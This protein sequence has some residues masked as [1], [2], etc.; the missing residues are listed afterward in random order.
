[1]DFIAHCKHRKIFR[2]FHFEFGKLNLS[3]EELTTEDG[4]LSFVIATLELNV[5]G[6]FAFYRIDVTH[7]K[8]YE[9]FSYK[10]V[11][12]VRFELTVPCTQ[13][14][15]DTSLRYIPILCATLGLY[16]HPNCGRD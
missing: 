11:G 5:K 3:V 9:I 6:L 8:R 4:K 13:N 12:M 10:M 2:V 14:K 7:N 16:R 1:M 15:C